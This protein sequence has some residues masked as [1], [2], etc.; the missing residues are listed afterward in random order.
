MMTTNERFAVEFQTD[1]LNIFHGFCLFIENDEVND[2]K[3]FLQ[4]LRKHLLAIYNS[5]LMLS[6]NVIPDDKDYPEQVLSHEL[7]A[8]M[9]FIS[10]RLVNNRYYWEVF[11][12]A[13]NNDNEAVCGDL[14]DDIEDIYEDIKNSLLLF[15]LNTED[16]K[17]TAMWQFESQYRTH[18]GDHCIN[19]LRACHYFLAKK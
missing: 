11:D 1:F 9:K 7:K 10:E 12:P 4:L 6:P 17:A 8:R 3:Q 5:G 18:W 15:D 14:I 19:A 16:A 13:D 2:V